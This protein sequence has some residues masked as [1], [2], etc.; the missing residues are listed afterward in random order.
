VAHPQNPYVVPSN[1]IADDVRVNERPLAQVGAKN[2]TTALGKALQAV[3]GRDQ[4]SR[5]IFGSALI[6]PGDV[7]VDVTDVAQ[8]RR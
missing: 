5:E 1:A 6:K 2:R 7:T 8:R 4:L 3:T